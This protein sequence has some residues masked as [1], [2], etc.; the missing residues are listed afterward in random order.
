M[1]EG[2]IDPTA[3]LSERGPEATTYWMRNGARPY[4]LAPA[5]VAVARA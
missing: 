2:L 3:Y 5:T 1:D 4:R